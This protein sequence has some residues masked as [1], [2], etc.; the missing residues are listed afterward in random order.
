MSFFVPWLLVLI[1]TPIARKLKIWKGIP[2][3]SPTILDHKSKD[4]R[5]IQQAWRAVTCLTCKYIAC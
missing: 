4:L 1:Q 3:Y 5:L 2:N